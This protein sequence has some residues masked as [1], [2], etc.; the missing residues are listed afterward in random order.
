MVGM[1]MNLYLVLAPS[2]KLVR[3]SPNPVDV[4]EFDGNSSYS[5]YTITNLSIYPGVDSAPPEPEPE[6][7]I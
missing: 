1:L 7:E 6:Y 4:V 5:V 2:G 3:V